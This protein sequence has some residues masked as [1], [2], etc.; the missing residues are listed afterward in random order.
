MT[1]IHLTLR[2]ED[3]QFLDQA[4]RSGR[5][6]TESDVIAAA[7]AELRAREARLDAIRSQLAVGLD[8]LDAGEGRP[9]DVRAVTERRDLSS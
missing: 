5:F 2:D 3:Q 1:T 9:W 6:A 7:I 4:I 8:Q